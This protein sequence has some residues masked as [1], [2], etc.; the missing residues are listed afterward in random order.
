MQFEAHVILKA[1]RGT[2]YPAAKVAVEAEGE[3]QALEVIFSMAQN[4]DESWI[5]DPR[6]QV[7]Y[8]EYSP[9]PA[10]PRPDGLRSLSVGDRVHLLG[11]GAWECQSFGWRFMPVC[12]CWQP[13]A[14]G[15]QWEL[16]VD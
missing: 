2:I 1:F 15:T 10:E 12:G 5:K 14:D 8:Q 4:V 3:Q 11:R 7:V 9:Q 16:S 13:S 6:V